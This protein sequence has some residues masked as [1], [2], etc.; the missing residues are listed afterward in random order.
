MRVC[1]SPRQPQESAN[2]APLTHRNRQPPTAHKEHHPLLEHPPTTAH[3]IS[4]DLPDPGG[5]GE[6]EPGAVPWEGYPDPEVEADKR[7]R[8]EPDA[9]VFCTDPGY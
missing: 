8:E 2:K 4:H 3:D 7:G 6:D 9:L 1:L 5:R